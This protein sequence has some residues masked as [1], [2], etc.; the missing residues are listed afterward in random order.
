VFRRCPFLHVIGELPNPDD[1]AQAM[2]N[3]L[4]ISRVL[5]RST[6]KFRHIGMLLFAP[7]MALLPEEFCERPR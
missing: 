1:A 6:H 7:A 5:G 3:P 4:E 2:N